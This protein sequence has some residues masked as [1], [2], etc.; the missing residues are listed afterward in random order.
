MCRG[1]HPHDL[2]VFR[3]AADQISTVEAK[4]GA[5]PHVV[6]NLSGRRGSLGI[7]NTPSDSKFIYFIWEENLGDI[8][9]MTLAS[10]RP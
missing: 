5:T 3:S 6:V 2:L 8:W 7:Y 4:P 10:S 9:T 1:L